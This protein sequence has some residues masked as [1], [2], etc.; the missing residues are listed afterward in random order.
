LEKSGRRKC[1]AGGLSKRGYFGVDRDESWDLTILRGEP[2]RK[3]KKAPEKRTSKQSHSRTE[4][5][6]IDL[7]SIKC[8]K[9]AIKK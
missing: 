7:L 3:E 1:H 8:K 2:K 5:S 9:E 4:S 6:S